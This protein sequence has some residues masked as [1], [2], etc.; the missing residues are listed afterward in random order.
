MR[1]VPTRPSDGRRADGSSCWPPPTGIILDAARGAGA[2]RRRHARKVTRSSSKSTEPAAVLGQPADPVTLV[3]DMRNVSVAR[4]AQRR[5]AAGRD[6]GRSARAGDRARRQGARA[7]TPRAD[8]AV[9]ALVRS[10]RNTIRVESRRARGRDSVGAGHDAATRRRSRRPPCAVKPT[11]LQRRARRHGTRRRSATRAKPAAPATTPAAASPAT[12]PPR[13]RHRF[14]RSRRSPCDVEKAT[15]RRCSSA[16][17]R[18]SRRPRQRSRSAA[19]AVSRR[20]RGREQGSAAPPGARLSERRFEGADPDGSRQPARDARARRPEQQSAA[21]HPRRHGDCA[22]AR[23]ITSSAAARAAAISTS[24]S[25]ARPSALP[26]RR[27]RR[28]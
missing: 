3:V 18:A 20:G 2:P 21:R 12:T 23:A 6:R 1:A 8:A 16:C 26:R 19:T 25:R 27:R 7:R 24:C 13:P 10:S 17:S 11:P 22:A 4:R 15:P 14:R 28:R 5:H 9:G